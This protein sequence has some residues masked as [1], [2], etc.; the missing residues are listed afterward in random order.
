LNGRGRCL[1]IETLRTGRVIVYSKTRPSF[2][3]SGDGIVGRSLGYLFTERGQPNVQ[4]GRLKTKYVDD[5]Q[6]VYESVLAAVYIMAPSA[7]LAIFGILAFLRGG[8]LSRLP[9][10]ALRLIVH[11]SVFSC[12][13]HVHFALAVC[14]RILSWPFLRRRLGLMFIFMFQAPLHETC[15]L[16]GNN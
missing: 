7:S 1:G 9:C 4:D 10:F 15:R 8:L 6:C 16:A 11:L 14:C 2:G 5:F 12:L 13:L 3:C